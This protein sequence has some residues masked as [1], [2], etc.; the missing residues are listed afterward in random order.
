MTYVIPLNS[1]GYDSRLYKAYFTPSE[2]ENMGTVMGPLAIAFIEAVNKLPAVV[3][4]Y[5]TKVVEAAINAYNALVDNDDEM[6]FLNSYVGFDA[7]VE[8]Y[9]K[10]CSEY[11]IDVTVNKINHL[12]DMDNSK[13]SYDIVK[14]ARASYLALTEAERALVSNAAVLD[15]KIADLAAAMGVTLDFSK[16][17]EEHFVTDE[18]NEEP[19]VV[20][21]KGLEL[22][23][24]IVIAAGSTVAAAAIALGIILFLKRKMRLRR[25]MTL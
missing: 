2:T 14:D 22:W 13:Y 3:T 8:K 25:Q 18:P 1:S 23:V 11:Y 17:Y 20:D 10:S 19:P 15:Q 5:D 24:I 12:F 16:T 6:A 9:N 7:Y 21:D 4:H